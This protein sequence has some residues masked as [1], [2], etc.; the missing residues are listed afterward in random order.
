MQLNLIS[1]AFGLFS[2][3][4]FCIATLFSLH[5]WAF[6]SHISITIMHLDKLFSIWILKHVNQIYCIKKNIQLSK[7]GVCPFLLHLYS[8]IFPCKWPPLAP[9]TPCPA[10]QTCTLCSTH[11]SCHWCQETKIKKLQVKKNDI[12]PWRFKWITDLKINNVRVSK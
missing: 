9:D 5:L 4:V 12:K 11:C 2:A 7:L 3:D 1:K 10:S 8:K 6:S